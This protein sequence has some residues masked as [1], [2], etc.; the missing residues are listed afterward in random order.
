M[1]A[2]DYLKVYEILN[3]H[4]NNASENETGSLNATNS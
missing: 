3:I 4:L 1:L 2:D